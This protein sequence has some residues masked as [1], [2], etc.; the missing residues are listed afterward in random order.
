MDLQQTLGLSLE[1]TEIASIFEISAL[2]GSF[3]ENDLLPPVTKA[4]ILPFL[5]MLNTTA[6]GVSVV[7]SSFSA[8]LL[9]FLTTMSS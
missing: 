3:G 2:T 6:V 8:P 9:N 7:V 4:C 5:S 1:I